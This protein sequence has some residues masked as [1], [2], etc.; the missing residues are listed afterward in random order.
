M[1]PLRIGFTDTFENATKFFTWLL[2]QRYD[3]IRDDENP[4]YL[5]FGDP[6]F[7]QNH[8]N[9]KNCKKIFYTG[10]NVRPN[11]FT[12]DHA[13]TFDHE[14]SPKHY[15][16]PLY[17]LEM[18]A[19]WFDDKL[20]PSLDYLA[21]RKIDLEAEIAKK[22]R[23]CSFVQSNPNCQPRNIIFQKL[24][25]ICTIDSGGPLFNN[26]GYILPRTRKDKIEFMS[27]RKFNLCCENGQYPGYVTEKLLDAYMANTVPIYWGSPTVHRDFYPESMV[28]LNEPDKF[29]E[30]LEG[31]KAYHGGNILHFIM[32]NPL[33]NIPN[34]FMNLN[35]FL[36]WWGDFVY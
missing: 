13:I 18:W 4:D 8:F 29:D 19:I 35:N 30:V 5:I 24:N 6:N 12:Y 31:L 32:N 22:T 34:E 20:A 23:F 33:H 2:S 28:W 9:Y 1:K 17:V 16:L 14:N 11:Y 26:M 25:N 36:D 27:T 21:R 15:R 10:E 7:G 3:V